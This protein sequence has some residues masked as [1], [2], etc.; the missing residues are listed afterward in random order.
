MQAE[1]AKRAPYDTFERMHLLF[2][3][4]YIQST[5]RKSN[6]KDVIFLRNMIPVHRRIRRFGYGIIYN[7]II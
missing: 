4:L 6:T 2:Y 7:C 3:A 5:Q 1:T